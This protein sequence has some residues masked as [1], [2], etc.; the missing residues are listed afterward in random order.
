MVNW[1]RLLSFR[2]F[3][4]LCWLWVI[5]N[6]GVL[7]NGTPTTG[8]QVIVLVSGLVLHRWSRGP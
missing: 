1:V 7:I 6:D 5:D 8:R 4:I 2:L 3:F